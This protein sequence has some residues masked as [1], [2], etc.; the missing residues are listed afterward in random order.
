MTS[1]ATEEPYTWRL[2]LYNEYLIDFREMLVQ[3]GQVTDFRS[4]FG[5]QICSNWYLSAGP[6][7]LRHNCCQPVLPGCLLHGGQ[8]AQTRLLLPVPPN[9]NW[10]L[11][12]RGVQ[13]WPECAQTGQNNEQLLS[14]REQSGKAQICCFPTG[15]VINHSQIKTVQVL[16]SNENSQI[17]V[18][19]SSLP[20]L[21]SNNFQTTG[22][23]S[24]LQHET[25]VDSCELIP[26]Y[27]F[28]DSALFAMFLPSGC[29]CGKIHPGVLPHSRQTYSEWKGGK[30]FLLGSHCALLDSVSLSSGGVGLLC[31]ARC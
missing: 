16:I 7:Q 6:A 24:Q 1:S 11:R 10:L 28:P 22:L 4:K 14:R 30:S 31:F 13:P 3:F 27:L 9:R 5:A 25:H 18:F 8:S 20:V 17:S 12:R 23:Q 15:K 29:G 2:H 21:R 26:R 19:G